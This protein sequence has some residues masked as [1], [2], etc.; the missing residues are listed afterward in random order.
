MFS[1]EREFD[2]AFSTLV[3]LRTDVLVIAP[4]RFP[5]IGVYIRIHQHVINRLRGALQH[6]LGHK[7]IQHTA[8]G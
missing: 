8:F 1:I 6:Y 2:A 4:I 7:D 5:A 3:K